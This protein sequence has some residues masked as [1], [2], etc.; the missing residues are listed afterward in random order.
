MFCYK[1]EYTRYVYIMITSFV[2]LANAFK[3]TRIVYYGCCKIIHEYL[4]HAICTII[5]GNT[6]Y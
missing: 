1:K 5:I 3:H 6:K 4:K 2:L